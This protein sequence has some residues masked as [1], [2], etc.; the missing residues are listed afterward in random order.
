MRNKPA[1]KGHQPA[2]INILLIED[3]GEI[4]LLL[5]LILSDPDVR[6][7]H[8][9]NLCNAHAFLQKKHPSVVLLD[10]RLPDGY[11]FDFIGYIKANSPETKV[12]MMSGVDKASGDFA[13]AAGA[14]AFL[15]K[16]FKKAALM[17]SI[18]AVLA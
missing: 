18:N 7:E 8:V 14:D 11:G 5:N 4:C 17:A 12:I 10:N 6:I 3:E 15:P 2:R 13:L 16:P 1:P 9:H